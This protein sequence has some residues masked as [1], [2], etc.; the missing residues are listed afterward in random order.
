MAFT[1]DAAVVPKE[2]VGP[3]T[4]NQRGSKVVPAEAGGLIVTTSLWPKPC[5]KKY[6]DLINQL[7]IVNKVCLQLQDCGMLPVHVKFCRSPAM[8]T[9]PCRHCS[10][11]TL[12]LLQTVVPTL[13]E[14]VLYPF[15]AAGLRSAARLRVPPVHLRRRPDAAEAVSALLQPGS[16]CIWCNSRQHLSDDAQKQLYSRMSTSSCI[17]RC[18]AQL[19]HLGVSWQVLQGGAVAQAAG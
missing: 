17:V 1:L 15:A 18:S 16:V 8:S 19:L 4:M 11:S 12:L 7:S 14:M 2:Q 5:A 13:H 3:F 9:K 10:Q 6:G